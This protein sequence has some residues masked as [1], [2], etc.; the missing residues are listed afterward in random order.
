LASPRRAPAVAGP[1]RAL[2]ARAA[3]GAPARPDIGSQ[4]AG[5]RELSG[6][7]P[8][9]PPPRAF[10]AS[11]GTASD[12]PLSATHQPTEYLLFDVDALDQ[13]KAINKAGR[14]VGKLKP[15]DN[16]PKKEALQARRA[17]AAARR[18]ARASRSCLCNSATLTH[19]ASILTRLSRPAAVL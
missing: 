10:A 9:A 3:S 5:L 1:G 13:N 12:A 16:A 14:L 6:G 2:A 4:P 7:P 18:S 11:P 8:A 17:A 19:T 15:V